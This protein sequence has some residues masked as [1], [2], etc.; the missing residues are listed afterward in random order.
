GH[1]VELAALDGRNQGRAISH[2][3]AGE[4]PE[5]LWLQGV[6]VGVD[7][8]APNDGQLHGRGLC[9]SGDVLGACGVGKGLNE[10][11]VHQPHPG[12]FVCASKVRELTGHESYATTGEEVAFGQ[13]VLKA[14]AELYQLRPDVR[15]IPVVARSHC[16]PP[17]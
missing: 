14:V 13:R 7:G 4:L 15:I 10:E 16:L 1:L 5:L 2:L 17:K 12:G 9:R 11:A 3:Y 8:D 6:A